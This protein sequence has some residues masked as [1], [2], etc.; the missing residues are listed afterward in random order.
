M[1]TQLFLA[2]VALSGCK[3]TDF[4]DLED[5]TWVRS[6]DEVDV[7][8]SDYA[9][10][11]VGVS[12]G[13]TGGSVAV[14]SD[15]SPVYSTVE[16]AADGSAEVGG[17]PLGLNGQNIG[18]LSET[19]VFISDNA[20]RIALIERSLNGNAFA[21]LFG[22][23]MGPVGLEFMSPTQPAPPPE[24]AVYAGNDLIFAAGDKIYTV[25][26]S[27]PPVA[28][29]G[30]DQ[31]S[32]PL[33]TAAIAADGT[34]LWVWTKS[35][36][37]L[38]WALTD[39]TTC[40][41]GNLPA[42]TGAPFVSTAIMPSSGS[43]VHLSGNYAVLAGRPAGSR[44]GQVLVVDTTSN[45]QVGTTLTIEGLRSTTLDTLGGSTYFVA[46][47]PEREIEGVQ[48]GVVE[49]YG[50]TP[51]TGA[52][53]ASPALTLHDAQPESGQTFGRSVTTTSFN[54]N[55]ILVVAGNLETFAYYRTALYD[56]LP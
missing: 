20:N 15:D 11:I 16:L 10:A 54:G 5:T 28:C 22:S 38:S 52:L 7:G 47:I 35:G 1:R 46:G 33:Q 2:I 37:L 30:L 9:V 51:A 13:T 50:F 45:M 36:A 6:V 14:A 43:R 44:T 25:P 19:P 31:A 49:L 55:R 24:S 23:P 18:A 40:T 3:W 39:V 32:M 56:H 29:T 34:R 53:D 41:G 8:A 26:Q 48:A 42:V 21:V 12:T 27:G 4:D 17:N